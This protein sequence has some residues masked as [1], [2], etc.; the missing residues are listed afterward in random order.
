MV[1]LIDNYIDKNHLSN[2]AIEEVKEEPLNCN[3]ISSFSLMFWL[4]VLVCFTLY[5]SF[6]PFNNIASAFMKSKYL[7]DMNPSAAEQVAGHYMA[8]PFFIGALFVPIFG[9]MIDNL[10]KRDL[11]ILLSSVFGLGSFIL[12]LFPIHPIFPLLMLGMTYSIFAGVIWPAIS[13]VCSEDKL[14][15]ALGITTSFQNLG[16]AVFPLIIAYI[17]T[18]TNQNYTAVLIFLMILCFISMIISIAVII[19]DRKLNGIISSSTFKEHKEVTLEQSHDEER[20][21]VKNEKN[22]D[23]YEKDVKIKIE[24]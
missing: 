4:V 13:L 5:G 18:K 9:Y 20:H 14:G 8:I 19:Q 10:G 6:M 2:D 24:S 17:L 7:S 22:E 3:I 11:F 1:I 21:Y 12:F 23:E 16:M 15:L